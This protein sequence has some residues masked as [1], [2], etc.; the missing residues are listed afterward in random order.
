MLPLPEAQMQVALREQNRYGPA[1][2]RAQVGMKRGKKVSLAQIAVT[3]TISVRQAVH[4]DAGGWSR[5]PKLGYVGVV[6]PNTRA[7]SGY[8]DFITPRVAQ[9][10]IAQ[11]MSRLLLKP[12]MASQAKRLL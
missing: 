12:K 10:Q 8:V 11:G 9:C 2:F 4:R 6:F 5:P 3:E 7:R 1:Q